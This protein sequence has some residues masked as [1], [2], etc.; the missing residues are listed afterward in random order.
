MTKGYKRIDE[1]DV[2][3]QGRR[4]GPRDGH[5]GPRQ[6]AAQHPAAPSSAVQYRNGGEMVWDCL[7]ANWGSIHDAQ[8]PGGQ[9]P[10]GSGDEAGRPA[11]G[12]DRRGHHAG[13]GRVRRGVRRPRR[14]PGHRPRPDRQPF[15]TGIGKQTGAEQHDVRPPA[16]RRPQL[17][18]RRPGSRTLQKAELNS[19][20]F[21]VAVDNLNL[22]T[23]GGYL[24][25]TQQ[26]MCLHPSAW[27]IIVGQL[28]RRTAYAG[29]AAAIAELSKSDR[30]RGAGRRC[31]GQGH[32]RGTVRG[33]RP[34]LHEHRRAAHLDRLRARW[35]G[36]S[37][38]R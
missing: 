1:L 9:A 6:A 2:Y 22:T 35:A 27:N 29:E 13:G 4:R 31:R 14:R 32:H 19:V 11:H 38:A 15:L 26:L 28:Q 25:V 3:H 7:H 37:W 24:N 36:R 12:H 33:G 10:L 8:R 18:D 34:G 20:K 30:H 16:H 5:R 21:D 17:Q 23:V